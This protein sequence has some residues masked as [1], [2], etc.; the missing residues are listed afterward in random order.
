MHKHYNTLEE[1]FTEANIL[2][3]ISS[4]LSWDTSTMMPSKAS[5]YRGKQL[6]YI[7]E[8]TRSIIF[9]PKVKDSLEEAYANIAMLNEWQQANLRSMQRAFDDYAAIPSKLQRQYILT[10]NHSEMV[11]REARAQNDFK[12]FVP[13]LSEAIKLTQDIA[14]CRSDYTGIKDRYEALVDTYDPGR[15]LSEIDSAFATLETFLPEFISKIRSKQGMRTS[16][17]GSFD[18][19]KQKALGFDILKTFNFNLD[20]GRLDTSTHP[21]CGGHPS[22]IRI[23]TRYNPNNLFSGL[24]GIIHETGHALYEQNRPQEWITQPVSSA[25][26][27]S[28][29]ESQ[30]LLAENQ[31]G[32]SKSFIEFLQP[33][34]MQLF[35]LD[36]KQFT[37]ENIHKYLLHVEPSFIRVEADEVT[38]PLHIILRYKLE[39]QLLEGSLSAEELP[40]AWNKEFKAYFGIT[41][42]TNAL[43]CLQDIHWAWGSFGYFPSYTL[44]AMTAAQ[45]MHKIRSTLPQIDLDIASGNVS[46]IYS[47]LSEYIHSKG[48]LFPSADL[49]LQNATGEVLNPKYFINYL[50]NKYDA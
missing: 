31:I 45:I 13:S 21:F 12:L 27:M 29:H 49:L 42:P 34:I 5:S 20:S 23:T 26:G 15:K 47:F 36:A 18:I 37:V 30:S 38:Y 48:S 16:F 14:A 10:C 35:T 24:Y 22:D 28:M 8:H 43:G 40:E 19:E 11:W 9:N 7:S 2:N 33:K 1:V 39:K 32:L 44:G 41:P 50:Q 3:Q 6:A 17:V 46:N 4:I 25:I